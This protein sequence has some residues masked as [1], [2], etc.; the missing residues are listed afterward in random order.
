MKDDALMAVW[1]DLR[2]E[3]KKLRGRNLFRGNEE[4]LVQKQEIRIHAENR[5]NELETGM[6]VL[7]VTPRTDGL[8]AERF[9]DGKVV[10]VEEFGGDWRAWLR[11]MVDE[12]RG[13]DYLRTNSEQADYRKVK[14]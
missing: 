1:E 13:E 5:K 6:Y 12:C 3:L 11:A 4:H 2:S 7:H 9:P 14:S 8:W 10:R